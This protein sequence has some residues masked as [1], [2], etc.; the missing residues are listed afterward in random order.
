MLVLAKVTVYH[1]RLV[2]ESF[3]ARRG[4]FGCPAVTGIALE[5]IST[6]TTYY[7]CRNRLAVLIGGSRG[8]ADLC[9]H[10]A[11][12]G[13]CCRTREGSNVRSSLSRLHAC[14][15]HVG[16]RA[17][18]LHLHLARPVSGF[19]LGSSGN[20]PDQPIFRGHTVPAEALTKP[21]RNLRAAIRC[22]AATGA[23]W[24]RVLTLTCAPHLRMS[25]SDYL[26]NEIRQAAERPTRDELRA[27]QFSGRYQVSCAK[28]S[29]RSRRPSSTRTIS[30]TSSITR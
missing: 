20:V 7:N 15:W 27:R 5:W 28:T 12:N 25:L 10:V 21:A 2:D 14:L 1:L 13:R 26:L 3:P 9:G 8:Q 18:G 19:R 4:K 23:P 30:A 17:D 16:R 22:R 29:S 6:T 11:R 24:A